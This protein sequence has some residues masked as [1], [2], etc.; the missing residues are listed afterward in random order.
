MTSLTHLFFVVCAAE[1]EIEHD[2]E[3]GA[4][5]SK[6]HTNDQ[7]VQTHF[8]ILPSTTH[9]SRRKFDIC[10]MLPSIS[11]E[12]IS[13]EKHTIRQSITYNMLFGRAEIVS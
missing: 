6:G 1:R 7:K 8:L 9:L 13:N 4:I 2:K 5:L 10:S 11:L 12:N 3:N